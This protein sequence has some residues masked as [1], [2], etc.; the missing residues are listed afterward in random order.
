[1]PDPIRKSEEYLLKIARHGTA[2]HVERLVRSALE[3]VMEE[4]FREQQG[5]PAG[6]LI[7]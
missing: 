4:D 1:L 5:V 3:Q 6:M 2:V 7:R